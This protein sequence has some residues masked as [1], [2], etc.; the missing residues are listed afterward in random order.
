M[1]NCGFDFVF[2]VLIKRL[3]ETSISKLTITLSVS[4]SNILCIFS[5][6][7]DD[8]GSRY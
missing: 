2:S 8:R 1:V 5:C 4:Q 7:V 6:D 3:A